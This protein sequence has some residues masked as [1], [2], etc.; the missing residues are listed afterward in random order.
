[1]IVLLDSLR[2]ETKVLWPNS[3]WFIRK[4]SLTVRLWS[5]L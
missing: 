3:F 4:P 1:M 5:F 2:V